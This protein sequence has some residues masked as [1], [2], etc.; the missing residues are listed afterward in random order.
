[1][2]GFARYSGNPVTG[3]GQ[4]SSSSI[5]IVDGVARIT[6]SGPEG[7]KK[8]EVAVPPEVLFSVNPTWVLSKKPEDS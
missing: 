2:P 4:E 6:E 1:M 8:Y 7:E 3:G 5:T